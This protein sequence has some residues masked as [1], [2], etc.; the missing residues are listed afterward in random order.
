MHAALVVWALRSDAVLA[1][2]FVSQWPRRPED[3]KTWS[4]ADIEERGSALYSD[5]KDELLRPSTARGERALADAQKFLAELSLVSWVREQ[6]D[7][8]GLAPSRP[9][10]WRRWAGDGADRIACPNVCT[11]GT[12]LRG[13]NQWMLRW[14]R[15]WRV[16]QGR[17]KQGD[18]L[19]LETFR[20][21]AG[22][23]A[24]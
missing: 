17:F 21:K 3:A 7:E 1:A 4:A 19:P 22:E 24:V 2:Q 10:I 13:R 11:D 8:K 15:R 6:N 16:V 18:R 14:A 23:R 20:A 9:A 5:R 12:Q